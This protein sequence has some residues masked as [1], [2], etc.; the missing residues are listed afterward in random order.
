MT[1]ILVVPERLHDLS[2]QMNQTASELHNLEGHLG[3]ALGG[4]DWQVRQ[5]ANV[6]GQVRAAQ[7]Q[8]RALAERAEAMARFLAE[9]ATAF[10]QADAEG[11]SVL[12]AATEAYRRPA[13]VSVQDRILTVNQE[14][15]RVIRLGEWLAPLGAATV[16]G[17][18]LRPGMKYAG[19]VIINL[20]N[21]LK[22]IKGLREFREMVMLPGH[23]NHFKAANLP[24]HML[25]WGIVMSIPVI[26][27]K[28]MT[29]F[30]EYRG[31]RLVSAVVVDAALTLA[32][33]ATSFIAAQVITWGATALGTVLLPGLGTTAGFAV[34]TA[35]ASLI[36]GTAASVGTQWAIDRY[37]VREKAIDVVERKLQSIVQ[38]VVNAYQQAVAV[39]TP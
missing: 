29:D 18:S 14:I 26:A 21:W 25:K 37:G 7:G 20:P 24:S 12:G 4:L 31:T 27:S 28:W 38:G 22:H 32:P 34:G 13:S 6:E 15:R 9:R 17:L 33:V 19:E 30:A 2:R 10:Q 23:F 3:R 8:A 1:R 5:Q 11:A 36:L 35:A 16:I 39:A